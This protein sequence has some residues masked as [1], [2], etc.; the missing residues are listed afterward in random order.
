MYTLGVQK[1]K[2][3]EKFNT[4]KAVYKKLGRKRSKA[5]QQNFQDIKL[6]KTFGLTRSVRLLI[7]HARYH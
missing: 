3:I 7:V 5:T 1:W 2:N 4:Y 6:S